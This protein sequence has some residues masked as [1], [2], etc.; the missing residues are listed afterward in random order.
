MLVLPEP[1]DRVVSL[2]VVLAVGPRRDIWEGSKFDSTSDLEEGILLNSR[3]ENALI[4]RRIWIST[5]MKR[6]RYRFL[7]KEFKVLAGVC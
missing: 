5:G 6:P 7:M 4:S 3:E 1:K 2:L